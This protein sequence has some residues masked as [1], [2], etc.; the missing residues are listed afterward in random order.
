MPFAAGGLE[1]INPYADAIGLPDNFQYPNG[2]SFLLDWYANN[3]AIA[4]TVDGQSTL[5]DA[6]IIEGCN[7]AQFTV[8][9]PEAEAAETDTLYLNLAG[10]AQLGLDY[11]ENFNQVIMGPELR[12]HHHPW[13][14]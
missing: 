14:R 9:R 4:V 6:N 8:I 2:E 3:E 10:S 1:N 12:K 13:G 7:D 5:V 11:A